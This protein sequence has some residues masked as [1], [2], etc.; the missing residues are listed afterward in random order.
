VVRRVTRGWHLGDT[1]E[2]AEGVVVKRVRN[3]EV[4]VRVVTGRG[5]LSRMSAFCS[6][7]AYQ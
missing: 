3:Q 1:E 5:P 4:G 7:M 2:S 6:P